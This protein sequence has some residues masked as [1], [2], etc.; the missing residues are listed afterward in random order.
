MPIIA[1]DTMGCDGDVRAAV[2]G[3]AA[4]SLATDIQV[5][6]VGNGQN[7]QAALEDCAYQP[8]R[9]DIV[10]AAEPPLAASDPPDRALRRGSHLSLAV[11][12]RLV[13]EGTVDTLVTAGN[14]PALWRL[15]R[16]RI[17]LHRGIQRAAVAAVYPRQVEDRVADP[18]ALVLDVGATVRCSAEDLVQFAFL[19]DAY[20]RCVSKVPAPRIALLNMSASA[21]AGDEV[22]IDANR[23]LRRAAR[24]NFVGNIE[25]HELASGRADVVICE[26][27]LGNVVV[28]MLHGLTLIAVDLA[29]ASIPRSWRSRA[30]MA[31]LGSGVDRRTPIVE[32]GAYAGAPI[33]GFRTVPI[34]CE[35]SSPMRATANAIKVAAKVHRDFHLAPT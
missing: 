25:G 35:P 14:L 7:I 11:A 33:L 4:V 17:P 3:A 23:R 34:Y 19:G 30:G 32:Y 22:L 13:A 12:T 5:V 28:K 24:L 9:I 29:T 1:V 27:L 15:W 21:T 6:L 20:A 26:G 10:D 31:M 18:L 2:A 16:D 8:E